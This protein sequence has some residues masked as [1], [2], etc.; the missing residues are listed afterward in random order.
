MNPLSPLRLVFND[1]CAGLTLCTG[2]TMTP[3]TN[4]HPV[5]L[6]HMLSDSRRKQASGS[7]KAI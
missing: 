2:V 3:V 1:S 4:D 7:F 6:S 5:C